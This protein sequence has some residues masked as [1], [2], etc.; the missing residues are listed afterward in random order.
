[1]TR[2]QYSSRLHQRSVEKK[3]K[4]ENIRLENQEKEMENCTFQ[5][6]TNHKNVPVRVLNDWFCKNEK[7]D[8]R[9]FSGPHRSQER[10][11][12]KSI[13]RSIVQ[14]SLSPAQKN[15]RQQRKYVQENL[16]KPKFRQDR[17]KEEIEYEKF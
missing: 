14:K 4:L 7:P 5:P 15:I 8:A 3:V 13:E 12:N 16:Y 2:K 6:R 9:Q 10:S 11:L 17:T 1:M